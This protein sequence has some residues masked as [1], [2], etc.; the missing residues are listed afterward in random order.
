MKSIEISGVIQFEH[1]TNWDKI[2]LVQE[3][4]YK[5]DLVTRLAEIIES[6]D[7]KPFQLSY[8]ISPERETKRELIEKH[9][10]HLS[11]YMEAEYT[12]DHYAYS[13]Y[14][15]GTDHNT[16]LKI[17]GH[18]LYRN[19]REHKGKFILLIVNLS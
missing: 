3:D 8:F 19:L 2:K 9:L 18:D 12:E 17:G 4:G 1:K 10:M 14:T 7:L 11:G 6:F 13:E 16:E 15:Q 5:I